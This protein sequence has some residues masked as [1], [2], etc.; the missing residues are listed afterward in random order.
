MKQ[1]MK[2]MKQMVSKRALITAFALMS[3]PVMAAD[4]KVGCTATGDCAPAM[5]AIEQG[6]FE[7]LGIDVEMVL[8]GN[9]SNI[10]AALLSQS[11]QMGGPTTS[12]FL[13]AIE[14]GLDLV[15][16]SGSSYM[17][18]ASNETIAAFV[19]DG[20]TLTTAQDFVGKRVGAPGLGAFLHVFF[21]KWLT[22]NGVDPKDVNFVETPFGN[23][24]DVIRTGAVDAVI[25]G[26][27]MIPRFLEAG[28]GSVGPK[29]ISELGG[30]A[31]VI[32]FAA[33]RGWAEANPELVAKFRKGITQGV[34]LMHKDWELA[35]TAIVN[36]TSE[37]EDLVRN[38]PPSDYNAVITKEDIGWWVDMLTEQ[39]ILRTKIDLEN[40][41]LK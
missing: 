25:T 26:G 23:M 28:I 36:F 30:D 7:K 40:I 17:S 8:I 5:V 29:Y 16:I 34:D 20:I 10:P 9:N 27:P 19:R 15:A 18:P 6:I 37:E 33:D 38:D 13:S 1:I 35:I 11:I 22:E 3:A 24:Q 12:V 31:P 4:I 14:G 21:V 2:T 32:F 41:V 39:D